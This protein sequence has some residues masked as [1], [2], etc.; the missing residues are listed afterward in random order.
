MPPLSVVIFPFCKCILFQGLSLSSYVTL[1]KPLDLAEPQF[2]HQLKEDYDDAYSH[3]P[4]LTAKVV[5]KSVYA[6]V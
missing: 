5:V 4:S 3:L 6:R 1:D 2:S